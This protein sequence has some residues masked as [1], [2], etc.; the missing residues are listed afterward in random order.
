MP[1]LPR[2]NVTTNI[3]DSPHVVIL[4]A[5]AS[6]AALPKG[7]AS[8][9][10]LPL[11]ANMVSVL[12]MEGLLAAHGFNEP[13]TDFEKFFSDLSTSGKHQELVTK[14]EQ[15][16]HRYFAG[17][18]L[19]PEPTLYDYLIL[20]LRK[21]DLIA[22]FNWDPFLAQAY[23]RN[24]HITEPSRIVF[25]HG[26]VAIGTCVEHQKVGFSHQRCADCYKLL[27]PSQLLYPVGEKDYQSDPY[28]KSEWDG[29]SDFLN[30]A[31]FVT[32]FGYSAPVTD[33]EAR[34]ILLKAWQDN[35]TRELAE[36]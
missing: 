28:I 25:L 18:K 8:G 4:G 14:I 30:E 1:T 23:Q 26:N 29:L 12:G 24:M 7:D 6:K 32:I 2:L 16:V 11:M 5:G 34:N 33:L 15:E 35:S 13:V 31:Y 20:S 22:T 3:N 36:I 19:P 17:L 21:T 27:S 9:K 10:E